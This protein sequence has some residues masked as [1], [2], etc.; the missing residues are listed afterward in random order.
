[1]TKDTDLIWHKDFK[2][3]EYDAVILP[4]GFSYGDH[5]RA[6]VIAA[7]S[8]AMKKVKDMA[9]EGKPILGICNGFQILVESEL[10]P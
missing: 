1:M 8:P 3:S 10:L 4:G 9:K 7:Y 2:D 5:L 6:G